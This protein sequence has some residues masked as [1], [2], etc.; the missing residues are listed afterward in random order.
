MY[1]YI[2]DYDCSDPEVYNFD[3]E[4]TEDANYSPV[5]EVASTTTNR[6]DRKYFLIKLSG[7]AT[8]PFSFLPP[9]SFSIWA[10]SKTKRSPGSLEVKRWPTNLAVLKWSPAQSKIFSTVNKVPLHIAFHYH[11]LMVLI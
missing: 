7:E 10:N 9:F 8:L 6:I 11:P 3:T 1:M 2:S 4:E 5:L